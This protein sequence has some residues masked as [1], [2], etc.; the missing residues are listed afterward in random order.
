[1]RALS[2]SS[3]QLDAADSLEQLVARRG[4]GLETTFEEFDVV[5]LLECKHNTKD[6]GI[7][8]TFSSPFST[9]SVK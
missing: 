9:I 7:A 4:E 5:R 6:E 3:D 2:D 1:M 8:Q